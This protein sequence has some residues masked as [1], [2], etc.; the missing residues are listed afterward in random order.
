MDFVQG[1]LAIMSMLLAIGAC[2][3]NFVGVRHHRTPVEIFLKSFA[4]QGPCA[5]VRRAD[6]GV[7]LLP[8][9]RETHLNNGVQ[10]PPRYSS[11]LIIE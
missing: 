11:L 3:D 7:D 8:S 1:E 9:S 10:T 5:N 2:A 4:N 6:A